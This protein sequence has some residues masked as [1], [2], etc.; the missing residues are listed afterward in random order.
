MSLPT[1]LDELFAFEA[2]IEAAYVVLL[3]A[4]GLPN[5]QS[6]RALTQLETP[7]I[8]LWYQNGAVVEGNQHQVAF[9]GI[10]W[11]GR[12]LP[13][14]SYTGTLTTEIVTNRSAPPL[15]PHTTYIAKLR[16]ALQLFNVVK[17]WPG[18]PI[19]LPFDIRENGTV[20]TWE[21]DNGLDHSTITWSSIHSIN[22]AAWPDISYDPN[23]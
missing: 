17:N 10:T 11:P 20:D 16:G 9:N 2:N 8:S 18:D 15:L 3:L 12:L 1:S 23:S 22:P 4:Y 21:D 14:N 6:S 5:A 7:Y 19:M 13:F